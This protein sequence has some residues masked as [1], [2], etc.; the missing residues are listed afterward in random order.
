M[1]PDPDISIAAALGDDAVTALVA[2][3]GG[4]YA[5][6]RFRSVPKGRER[7]TLEAMQDLY[8]ESAELRRCVLNE[9]PPAF[10]QGRD[11]VLEAAERKGSGCPDATRNELERWAQPTNTAA[12]EVLRSEAKLRSLLWAVQWTRDAQS[13][14]GRADVDPELFKAIRELVSKLNNF[15]QMV[16]LGLFE[17][18]D[19]F[20]LLHRSIAPACK[21]IEPVIWE[22]CTRGGRWGLRLLRLLLRAEHFNDVRAVHSS[23]PLTWHRDG[24]ATVV[25]HEPLYE[26]V[27]DRTI[28]GARLEAMTMRE[29]TRM[30]WESRVSTRVRRRFGGVR[31]RRHAAAENALI[32]ELQFAL[33]HHHD[34]LQFD[35]SIEQ[36]RR[37]LRGHHE[38]NGALRA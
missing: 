34:P 26:T 15:A 6:H 33:A 17:E 23:S 16:E 3:G 36:L 10:R 38:A 21:A 35:W 29:R 32:G 22:R 8:A 18:T 9:M 20:G 12:H 7:E 13:G 4:A 2:F 25:I 31:L 28:P 37:A 19:V 24:F 1:A 5:M 11:A 14:D 27:F 30:T